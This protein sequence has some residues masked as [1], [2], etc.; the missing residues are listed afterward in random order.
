MYCE[1]ILCML[2]PFDATKFLWVFMLLGTVKKRPPMAP[3]SSLLFPFELAVNDKGDVAV[4]PGADEK[5]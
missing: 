1:N 2:L 5:L 4:K 3:M